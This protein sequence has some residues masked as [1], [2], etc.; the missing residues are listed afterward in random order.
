MAY[1][2]P[3]NGGRLNASL[4][5]NS[6][7]A[8]AGYSLL[9]TGTMYL[10]GG[11]NIT[12]SQNGAS[13]TISGAN[14]P[15]GS[16]NFSAGTTSNNLASVTFGDGNGVSF[17]LNGSTI[18]A[19]HNGLTSQSNQALSGSNGSFTFQTATL[20]NLNGL[21]FYTSNGSMV[22]SYTVPTQTNQTVGIYATGANTI[23]QSSSSTLDARSLNVSGQG[24]VS[25]GLSG[26]TLQISAPV[27]SAQTQSNIAGVYDGANSISTGTVQFSN[28]NGVSFGINGQTLTA[29]HNGITSQTNQTLGMTFTGNTTHNTTATVDAR[30]LTF[31]GLGGVSVGYS[32]GSFEISAGASAGVAGFANSQTTFTSGT[33]N[34]VEA[35]GALT[36]ASTTGQSFKL[37]VPASS[38]LSGANAVTLSSN[39]STISIGAPVVSL[40]MSTT[41]AGG[42]TGGTSG[43]VSNGM[44]LV[45]GS[46]ITL[47]QSTG[48]N[49]ATVSIYGTSGGGGGGGTLSMYGLGNTTQNS[50][51]SLDQRSVSLNGLGGVSV[52][53]SNGSVQL[54]APATSSL[55]ATGG[56]SISTN[57]STISVG[58]APKL[59]RWEYPNDVFA[60][61][62]TAVP[63]SS[64]S[65]QPMYVPFNVT[66]TAMKIG[67]SMTVGTFTSNTTGSINI[68]LWMGIYT[69]SGSSLSLA[70]SGSANN[71]FTW[72]NT[73]NSSQYASSYLGMREMTVPINV[74]MTPGQYWVAAAMATATTV[75]SGF[76][77]TL[78]G[79]TL[80]NTNGAALTIAPMGVNT[81]GGSSTNLRD[82]MLFEGIYTA[83]TAAGP[84]SITYGQLNNSANSSA[85]LANF[86]NVI[87]NAT[88]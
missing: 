33:V 55:S 3:L 82:A 32:N 79:N 28:S 36:I 15:S 68:S 7:S 23:G 70:S 48:A 54:S 40:G 69:L 12:L 47:S 86:Y 83:A 4:S 26:S 59:S 35:G 18:T 80:M 56:L 85:Q 10:A 57:G 45:A 76:S 60:A 78:Y 2:P 81:T 49:G 77:Y 44:Y 39:G 20:G 6:T 75:T 21:S 52:G 41:T 24:A 34:F 13:V 29:S 17:G 19:S 46:N 61:L 62:N 87:Y 84:A 22:G 66:G 67:G 9:S 63:N 43:T 58:F 30:S 71:G 14:A 31:R 51:T 73:G 74:N 53:Y 1:I 25:V 16:I 50:S 27:Q 64:L 88:Y 37:S 65:V 8:G 5:G 11:N 38:S 42:G 72:R